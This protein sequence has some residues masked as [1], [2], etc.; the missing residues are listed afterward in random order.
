MPRERT[1][2]EKRER[3]DEIDSVAQY[4]KLDLKTKEIKRKPISFLTRAKRMF[5]PKRHTVDG[6][7]WWVKSR[8]D[9]EDMIVMPEPMAHDDMPIKGHERKHQLKNGWSIPTTD[10][11]YLKD[12]PLFD[13]HDHVLL[14]ISLM[15]HFLL[16]TWAGKCLVRGYRWSAR[17]FGVVN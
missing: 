14:N 17:I 2:H 4:W 5:L 11:K 3:R 6:L 7:Y 1:P 15:K 16:Y 8:T 9:D 13:E 10:L 12:G